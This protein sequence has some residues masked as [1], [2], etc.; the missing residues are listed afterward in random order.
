[1][2]TYKAVSVGGSAW[3]LRPSQAAYFSVCS[4]F[5]IILAMYLM[6]PY[7]VTVSA[8][9]GGLTW[10]TNSI[11]PALVLHSVADIVVVTRWW[12]TGRPEW[13]LGAAVPPLVR[14]SG[15][16]ASFLIAV[17]VAAALGAATAWCDRS[18]HA[19]ALRSA[20]SSATTVIATNH[21]TLGTT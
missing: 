2:A 3:G 4:T 7:Y 8:M 15:P 9:Y 17:L 6:L 16:N 13:Q 18:V 21:C 5:L 20:P 14:D 11:V 12:V 1:V 10:A 19:R